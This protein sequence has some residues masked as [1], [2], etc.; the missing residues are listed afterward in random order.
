[1]WVG[2]GRCREY[3]EKKREVHQK[4]SKN[5]LNHTKTPKF[6]NYNEKAQKDKSAVEFGHAP[7]KRHTKTKRTEEEPRRTEENRGRTEENRGR[8]E[9]NRG[10][11][12]KA[13]THA[14]L[15]RSRRA[16]LDVRPSNFEISDGETRKTHF[17][18]KL[19]QKLEVH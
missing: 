4:Q 13:P 8:T 7:E 14:F 12:R 18:I 19:E 17:F 16:F 6:H 9:E 11:P 10:E 15:C 1:M 5:T 2:A 3:L